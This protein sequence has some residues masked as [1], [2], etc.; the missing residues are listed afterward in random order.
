[1]EEKRKTF[2]IF[3]TTKINVKL[4]KDKVFCKSKEINPQQHSEE[5]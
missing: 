2:A 1:M 3:S 4:K 5:N